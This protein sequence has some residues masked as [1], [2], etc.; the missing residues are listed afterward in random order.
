MD[1]WNIFKDLVI[2]DI[3]FYGCKS[4]INGKC[5]NTKNVEECINICEKSEDCDYGYFIKTPDNDNLCVPL[6]KHPDIYMSPY[7]KMVPKNTFPELKTMETWLFA[8]KK[9]YPYPPDIPNALFYSDPLNISITE[10]SLFLTFDDDGE[11]YQSV[12]FSENNP[13]LIQ[14]LP[15]EVLIDDDVSYT[16]IKNG[17]EVVINIPKTTLT[18]RKNDNNSEVVW[19][20]RIS[21]INDPSRV[22]TLW[23]ADKNKK[24]GELL[25]YSESFYLLWNNI[26]PL[27]YD[28]DAEMLKVSDEGLYNGIFDKKKI[29]F[30]LK[31]KLDV[32]FCDS[33]NLKT[34]GG[35]CTKIPLEECRMDGLKA[36]TPN[37]IRTT[38]NEKCWNMCQQQSKLNFFGFKIGKNISLPIIIILGLIILFFIF[39]RSATS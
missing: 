5:E 31:P 28:D 33:L 25:D 9:K 1:N 10:D 6:Y 14:F 4:T 29:K 38:R 2:S 34:P 18:L 11:L 36:L 39:R 20:S 32:Y 21:K 12:Y 16:N 30:T 17:D 7:Y 27:L 37:G 13:V 8:N 3:N 24:E 35:V 15:L 19:I 23:S 26:Y 22:F